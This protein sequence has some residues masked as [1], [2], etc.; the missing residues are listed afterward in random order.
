MSFLHPVEPSLPELVQSCQ[1]LPRGCREHIYVF[2]IHGMDPFDY[3]NLNGV[4]NYIHKLGFYQTYYGQL[5]HTPKFLKEIRR[6]H[7][8]D[9]EAHF[10]LI[11]FSF[12]ANMVR[13]LAQSVKGDGIAIDLLFYLGGN[14]LENTPQDQPENA[15]HIVNILAHGYIWNGAQMDGAENLSEEDVWHFG[16]PTHP[17]TLQVL[18]RELA[19]IAMSVPIIEPVVQPAPNAEPTPRP[20]PMPTAVHRDEWDFLKPVA[21]LF[22]GSIPEAGP[23]PALDKPAAKQDLAVSKGEGKR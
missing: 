10:V 18:T 20:V 4:N 23:G 13:A 5:Y 7:Q 16:S 2:M 11:G 12:G 9:P 19:S 17:R 8:Q 22:E 6:I 14:T 3:A 15:L 1:E 21:R